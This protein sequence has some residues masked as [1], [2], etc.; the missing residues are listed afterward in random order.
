MYS[1]INSK[2]LENGNSD[3]VIG[4]TEILGNSHLSSFVKALE[5]HH[6]SNLSR[7]FC[8][9][10]HRALRNG[11]CLSRQIEEYDIFDVPAKM[12]SSQSLKFAKLSAGALKQ[13]KMFNG[14]YRDSLI[15]VGGFMGDNFLR[16][17]GNFGV[18]SSPEI[19]IVDRQDQISSLFVNKVISR[20][21]YVSRKIDEALA[22]LSPSHVRWIASPLPPQSNAQIRFGR[23]YIESRSQNVYNQLF[24]DLATE[25]LRQH[26]E[27]GLL[28]LQPPSTILPSGFSSDE[29]AHCVGTS[30]IHLNQDFYSILL[31]NLEFVLVS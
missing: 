4:Y 12:D 23:N 28:V 19:P 18:D 2:H 14:R 9:I 21:K 20:L 25:Y 22:C 8:V 11:L 15:I 31:P 3:S 24:N 27:T 26:I 17:H 13:L 5:S 16:L 1:G 29:Y 7:R 6:N 10:D 30:D